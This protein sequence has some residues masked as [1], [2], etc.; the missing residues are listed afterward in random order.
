MGPRPL[1]PKERDGLLVPPGKA[2]TQ[3]TGHLITCLSLPRKSGFKSNHPYMCYWLS[4]V[5]LFQAFLDVIS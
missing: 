5:V 1:G 2:Y 3:L 4:R